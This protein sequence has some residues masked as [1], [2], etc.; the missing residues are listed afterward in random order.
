MPRLIDADE[1]RAAMKGQ[2][3]GYYEDV[4]DGMPTVDDLQIGRCEKCKYFNPYEDYDI[5][6]TGICLRH[7]IH[8]DSVDYCSD[9]I[10]RERE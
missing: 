2:F 8:R 10:R 5:Y 9:W 4:L 6:H 3:P 1:Y 7:T